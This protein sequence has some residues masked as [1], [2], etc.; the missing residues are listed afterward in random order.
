[1]RLKNPGETCAKGA[2][3]V[4]LSLAL[5]TGCN[6]Q[7]GEDD[8]GASLGSGSGASS[9]GST[10]SGASFGAGTG[11][12][13][14]GPDSGGSGGDPGTSACAAESSDAALEPVYLAFAFDVSGS[15]GKLDKPYHDPELKWKP[16]VA[17]TEA[18]FESPASS[19]LSASLTFFPIGQEDGR[20]DMET[21]DTPD[22]AMTELPSTD[23]SDAITAITPQSANEWRGGTP[24]LAVVQ[25]TLS[26]LQAQRATNPTAHYAL[27]LVTDGYPNG[28]DDDVADVAAAVEAVSASIPTYVIGVK[29]P[30]GGPDAV[31]DL[32]S[33]AVAGG[34]GS[35]FFIETGD[36]VA[37]Q[38]AFQTAINGIRAQ[39]ISCDV[40]IPAPPA[41][42]EF[43]PNKVNVTFEDPS[44]A[45]SFTYDP[46]CASA[47]AWR[48]DDVAKPTKIELCATTCDGV[49]VAVNASLAVEFGCQRREIIR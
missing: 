9:T 27:V 37:T 44:G 40:T 28:C 20:C 15:M 21:Y 32:E 29:N 14:L 26:F 3:A 31:T 48:Y 5:A 43:D 47:D 35:A 39:T 10:G 36:P 4:F 8:D 12:I 1:M 45:K 24:T 13:T 18:F 30:E 38:T 49:Q 34:T 22:V 41:G 16:V 17:A 2:L 23:F 6:G 46:E 7:K 25:G 33:I 42:Q 11:G 19:G